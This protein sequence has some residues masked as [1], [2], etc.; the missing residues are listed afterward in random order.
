MH[1]PSIAACVY[2]IILPRVWRVSLTHPGWVAVRIITAMQGPQ[3]VRFLVTVVSLVLAAT[4]VACGEFRPAEPETAARAAEIPGVF[5]AVSAESAAEPHREAAGSLGLETDERL[6]LNAAALQAQEPESFSW[7]AVQGFPS[8]PLPDGEQPVLGT[9]ASR[10]SF[11]TPLPRSPVW[12]P[13]GPKRV[14]IQ[15][16]HWLTNEVPYEL[17]RLSPGASAGGWN[18]FEVNLLIARRVATMLE[19]AG[20]QVDLLPTTIPQR[21]RAHAFISI[22]ADGDTSGTMNGYKLT[23]PGFSSIPEADDEFVRTMYREYGAATGMVR[24]SDAHV[25]RRMT[26]YYAF[27]TRRYAHAIDLGTP[28]IILETGF[29]TN[30]SDRNFLTTRPDLPARGIANSVLRFLELELGSDARQQYWPNG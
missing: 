1:Q 24:D 19:E 17:R 20:V 3:S 7:D 28:A 6:M 8:Y 23:R 30:A 27:N 18:E 16:G 4:V 5:P 12:N 11:G 21:Y 2:V 14:G 10:A 29:L 9:D 15:A 22:H 25:S 13:P 26:F